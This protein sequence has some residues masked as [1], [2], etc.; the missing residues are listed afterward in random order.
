MKQC[1]SRLTAFGGI[2]TF[3]TAQQFIIIIMYQYNYQRIN[4]STNQYYCDIKP[5][6]LHRT[7]I[8]YTK[9]LQDD[10]NPILYSIYCIVYILIVQ[11]HYIQRLT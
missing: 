11:Q 6:S 4:K 7:R 3:T 8:E 9:P 2:R 10:A 5:L 1:N